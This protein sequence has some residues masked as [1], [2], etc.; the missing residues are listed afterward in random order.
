MAHMSLKMAFE[1]SLNVEPFRLINQGDNSFWLNAGL[2]FTHI[3]VSSSYRYNTFL[4]APSLTKGRWI[5]KRDGRV[6]RR[7]WAIFSSLSQI[8]MKTPPSRKTEPPPL[9]SISFYISRRSVKFAPISSFPYQGKV[10]R[11]ARR[12]GSPQSLS[13]I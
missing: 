8:T 5:A 4:W 11:G 12:K 2:S 13:D 9:R 7:A 10:A 1:V 6:L 3:F